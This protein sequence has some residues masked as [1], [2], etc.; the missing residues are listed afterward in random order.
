MNF[1]TSLIPAS[2]FCAD[3]P[4]FIMYMDVMDRRDARLVS[5]G[6]MYQEVIESGDGLP[7]NRRSDLNVQSST[8]QN[9]SQEETTASKVMTFVK[10]N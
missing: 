4:W 2:G 10:L 3:C 6:L 9:V 7:E 8:T 5:P 1:P